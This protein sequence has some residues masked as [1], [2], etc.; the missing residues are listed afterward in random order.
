LI[1]YGFTT[2]FAAAELIATNGLPV[3]QDYLAGLNPTNANSRFTV[4]TAFVPG[5]TPQ[6]VFSTVVGRMY[7]LETATSLDSWSVLRDNMPGIGGNI[8]FI[9]NR[10]LSGV[11]SVFYRVAVY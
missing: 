9:D 1:Y 8:L 5:Q 11:S 4:W 10:T 6:I 2:N 7:R 3:W